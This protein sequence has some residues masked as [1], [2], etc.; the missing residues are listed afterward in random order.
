MMKTVYDVI[1][2]GRAVYD[3]ALMVDKYP[4][5]DEKTEAI[6]RYEGAGSPIPNALCQLAE[7]GKRVLMVAR[8]GDDQ[9]GN[10][11][12]QDLE[13]HNVN[14]GTVL[15]IEGSRTPQAFLLVEKGTGKRTVVLDRTIAPLSPNELPFNDLRACRILHLD[16]WEADAALE[17]ARSVHKA[18]GTVMLDAGNIRPRMAELLEATDWLVAPIAFIRSF[19]G[20]IDLF[21]AVRDLHGRG[22][23][24][25]VVTN[26]AG[27]CVAAWDDEISWFRAYSAKAVDT[28]GAGDLFHAGFL[29]GLL[30]GWQIPDCIR[31]AAATASIAVTALGGRGR[32]AKI[33]EVED[34]LQN[35]GEHVPRK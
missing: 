34:L 16:G 18:G 12:I 11:F 28:T 8:V 19:Y 17:A 25:A 14:A 35:A 20:E 1:G 15:R 30:E 22:P 23:R 4:K 13:S 26:G 21:E 2:V 31:W 24:T 7:W 5:I 10:R 33:G 29:H 9:E 3:Y 32:L 6:A 27:G